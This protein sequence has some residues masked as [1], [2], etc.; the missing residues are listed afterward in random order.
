MIKT[1][2]NKMGKEWQREWSYDSQLGVETNGSHFKQSPS[3][4]EKQFQH[5]QYF[6]RGD[7]LNSIKKDKYLEFRRTNKTNVK[8]MRNSSS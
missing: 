6:D 5:T 3:R 1:A 4:Y 7:M 8:Q 2:I